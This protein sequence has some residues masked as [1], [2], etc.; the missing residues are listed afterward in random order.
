MEDLDKEYWKKIED[1]DYY[2]STEGRVKNKDGLIMKPS[3]SNRGSGYYVLTLYKSGCKKNFQV[4]RLVGEAFIPNPNN[5]S[6]INHKNPLETLNNKLSNLEW[7]SH[8][9]NNQSK[10]KT[11]NLGG[12]CKDHNSFRARFI[13]YGNNYN[14]HNSCEDKCWDWLYARRIEIK[15]GLKLTEV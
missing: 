12:V 4:H 14:F 5:L 8:I 3:I 6:Q 10:N 9:E 13:Y 1:Y 11:I 2:V 7:V 15:Y